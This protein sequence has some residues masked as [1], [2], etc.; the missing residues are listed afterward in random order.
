MWVHEHA[1]E[2]KNLLE[3]LAHARSLESIRPT[4]GCAHK[5]DSEHVV[6]LVSD[7]VVALVIGDSRVDGH[8]GVLGTQVHVVVHLPVNLP[9]LARR[10]EQ[11]LCGVCVRVWWGQRVRART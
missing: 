10:V 5:K 9:H 6:E 11:P 4:C 7:I 3:R 8:E 2:E 1:R